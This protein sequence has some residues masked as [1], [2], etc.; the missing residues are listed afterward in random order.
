[1]QCNEPIVSIPGIG[2]CVRMV[3]GAA[4]KIRLLLKYFLMGSL[5]AVPKGTGD[6]CDTDISMHAQQTVKTRIPMCQKQIDKQINDKSKELCDK[7]ID[8]VLQGQKNIQSGHDGHMSAVKRELPGA[9]PRWY[10][11][12]G[13]YTQLNRALAELG[14]TLTLIPFNGRHSCPEFRRL[15]KEKYDNNTYSNAI[16]SGKMFQSDTEYNRALQAFLKHNKVTDSTPDIQKNTV[17]AQFEKNNFKASDLH[18]G[19][20]IIVQHN[21]TPSN[22]HAIMYLGRGYVKANEFVPDSNG[23]FIY[24]GYNN[25]TIGNIFTTYNTNHLFT[26]D[27]YNIAT[28]EY[29]K[30]YKNIMNKNNQE[31]F[32]YVY[33]PSDAMYCVYPN[34]EKL[35]ELA[36]EKYFNRNKF[37]PPELPMAPT[38]AKIAPFPRIQTNLLGGQQR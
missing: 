11:I 14:D 34:R 3:K 35:K 31:L 21:N 37:V 10:C 4:M 25:E 20:I 18:P 5:L 19:T 17:V 22:T 38:M 27:I 15:M 9:V 23:E 12:Y 33:T 7:Y 28:V 36:Q 8:F 13:Q 16:H 1:M 24:A 2:N 26:A 30:E 29:T 6:F 32:D